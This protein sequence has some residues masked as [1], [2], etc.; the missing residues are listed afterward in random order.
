MELEDQPI[1]EGPVHGHACHRHRVK[2][3]TA[4]S[5]LEEHAAVARQQTD[6]VRTRVGT[7]GFAAATFVHRT[8]R[9]GDP[10]LHTHCVIPNLAQG[11]DGSCVAID[12]TPLWEW[13]KA[14]GSV[15]QEQLRT[16]LSERLGVTWASDRNGCREL[17]GITPAQLRA[18]SKGAVRIE[19]RLAAW[20][21]DP[22]DRAKWMQAD[23][24]ASKATRPHKD[25][26]LT[27]V[28]LAERWQREAH[29]AGLPVGEHL[30]A[31]VTRPH[32]AH[33]APTREEVFAR[34]VDQDTG[35]CATRA[36]F[37]EAHVVEAV[38]AMGTGHWDPTHITA[39]ARE[40]LASEDG[41]RLIDRQV[42]AGRQRLPRFSTRQHIALEQHVTDGLTRLKAKLVDGSVPGAVEDAIEGKRRL[43]DD[44][45]EAVRALCAPG[46]ALRVMLAPPGHG[47][48]TT[49]KTAACVQH[50]NSRDV[51]AVAT[52]HQAV[53]EL[54]NAGLHATTLARLRIDLENAQLPRGVVVVVDEVSQ[55]ATVDAAWLV[56]AVNATPDARL[57]CLGDP[58]QTTPV[59]AGG[60]AHELHNLTTEQ[61]A[62]TE[63]RRQVDAAERQALAA[64]RAGNP[65]ESQAIR[66]DHGWEHDH[67][68]PDATRAA[69]A[70]AVVAD[71]D[72]HGVFDVAA[73]AVSHADCEDIADRVRALRHDRGELAGMTVTG[74][75]WSRDREYA[76][77]DLLLV[78]TNELRD[79]GL[80]NGTVL[81]IR[82][83]TPNWVSVTDR[84]GQRHT[85]AP[86][87]LQ[88][89]RPDGSPNVSHG[90][91]RTVDGAQ[92]GTWT[93]VH[94][95][96]TP[97]L[98]TRTA[99]VGQSRGRMPTHTWNTGP[100]DGGDHGGIIPDDRTAP[101]HVLAAMQRADDAG[102]ALADDPWAIDQRF[103]TERDEH[104]AIIATRPPDVAGQL[105]YV[106]EQ[107]ARAE[108]EHDIAQQSL[109]L[110]QRHV[111]DIGPLARLRAG[112][113]QEHDL[114]LQNVARAEAHIDGAA[115]RVHGLDLQQRV[116]EQIS[117]R[118]AAWDA[119]HGWRVDRVAAIDDERAAHWADTVVAAV[120]NGDPLAYSIDKL[121]AAHA[122]HRTHLD[123]VHRQLPPDRSSQLRRAEQELHH[124]QADLDH[125]HK[126][127]QAARQ[128]LDAAS[129]RRWGRLD[130]PRITAASDTLSRAE[131]SAEVPTRRV[132][133]AA[134]AF[135]DETA[136]DQ[137]R[138]QALDATASER[139]TLAHAIA[140]TG[141]VLD[142]DREQRVVA[143]ATAPPGSH[144]LHQLLGLPPTSRGG[145]AA[146]CALADHHEANQDGRAPRH[147][148]HEAFA[149]SI[150]RY[151]RRNGNA[152]QELIS[153]APSVI[154]LATNAD[155]KPAHSI[156]DTR[157][158]A[159][160]LAAAEHARQ[161]ALYAERTVHHGLSRGL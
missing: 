58:Q 152:V 90:W 113:R 98:D 46:S 26:T 88:G 101:E 119:Q 9:E 52:T 6:G 115:D 73:L 85:L 10:Q 112:G 67:D 37:T 43:G 108:H 132:K 65:A 142:T 143:A 61:R 18:F 40:F 23:E 76:A 93:Q 32:G 44:Q 105:D 84:W 33:A 133:E 56:D 27:P 158:R 153:V 127:L 111:R 15:Y 41:V 68:T 147:E 102:F 31:A 48:T 155:P 100:V 122:T 151:G 103:Q 64:Y 60:L 20:G 39:L 78:H 49:V 47:K 17:E 11:P 80:H 116:L 5:F 34:L 145:L 66:I 99:Y 83:V 120:R 135:R 134:D 8:S 138:R 109:T 154:T 51:L 70:Q 117:H 89:H 7:E 74:P 38:A 136:H 123:D 156:P 3:N 4:L 36:R 125:A 110:A 94:L 96:A 161:Q 86:S 1:L 130:K 91:C 129:Q 160:A 139:Q 82:D 12:G 14:T 24:N 159:A 21:L 55:V 50:L 29:R 45:A 92:G 146:W 59:R 87:L 118:R 106:N 71:G 53:A 97:R 141:H 2:L 144:H 25:P 77:G 63:N 148:L 16:L 104:T 19:A 128:G 35:L 72:R 140:D 121:R 62:L 124:H 114:A 75:G 81:T 150:D 42:E 149:H 13:K 22:S 57:W 107:R 69:M 30:A 137:R 95:L 79:R 126:Q 131:Y 157:D 28:T 54:R